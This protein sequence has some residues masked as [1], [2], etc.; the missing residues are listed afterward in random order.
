MVIL[1]LK[2]RRMLVLFVV[3]GSLAL[4][5]G[6]AVSEDNSDTLTT[7][8]TSIYSATSSPDQSVKDRYALWHA[9]REMWADEPLTGVG[10]RNFAELRDSYAPLSF[11]GGSDIAD[12]SGGYRRVELLSPHSFYWLILAE[13]GLAGALAFGVLFLSLGVAS[14]RRSLAIEG[15][16]TEQIFSLACV[17]FLANYL[18]SGIYMDI[19]G[20]TMLLNSVFFGALVWVASGTSL[21][22]EG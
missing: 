15:S 13:Q 17:G 16:A 22:E 2:N 21:A 4:G 20:P 19:G 3:A 11:S 8:L 12:S 18:V 5:I 1:A 14:L 10:I 6:L 9:A 7:R